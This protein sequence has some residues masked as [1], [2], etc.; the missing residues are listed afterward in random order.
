MYSPSEVWSILLDGS[1]D[2]DE[3]VDVQVGLARVPE[4][5]RTFLVALS[6]G[7]TARDALSMAGLTGNQ[8]RVKRDAISRLVREVNGE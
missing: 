7:Y 4:P 6:E 2:V 8:T 3:V 1:E 5:Q